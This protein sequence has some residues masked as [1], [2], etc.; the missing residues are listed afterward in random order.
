MIRTHEAMVLRESDF[1]AVRINWKPKPENML[2]IAQELGIKA[3]SLVF[4]DD[5]PDEREQMRQLLPGV[6]TV[7]LPKDPALY[8]S[9]L[10][11]LPQLQTLT[12]IDEDR[13][14]ADQ[15][16]TARMR[17]ET[18]LS[19][20]S[21]DEYL[22][23]LGIEVTIARAAPPTFARIAQLFARTNQFNTTTRRYT[24][25]DV[26]GF[27]PD[28]AARLWVLWSKDRFGDHGLVALALVRTADTVWT[29]DSFLM[30]CRVIGYGIDSTLLAHIA[31]EAGAAGA[32]LR[33][34]FIP[35]KKNTPAMDLFS[36]RG[37][38]TTDSADGAQSWRS[39]GTI[40]YPHW[41]KVLDDGA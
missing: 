15:Y 32:E 14:R 35:T 25:A 11:R 10:E 30:S 36:R 26:A 31:R 16:R 1:S 37:F 38:A 9:A 2:S 28:P 27:A 6:L 33:A 20:A 7:D 41:V 29:I 4:V 3:D 40:A 19:G 5:N 12:V 23:S 8:R 21:V 17:E 24:A 13:V 22:T 34:E 39:G 18:K